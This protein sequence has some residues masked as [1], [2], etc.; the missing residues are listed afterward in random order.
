MMGQMKRHYLEQADRDAL[1]EAADKHWRENPP[2]L[3]EIF[4]DGQFRW[5]SRDVDAIQGGMRIGDYILVDDE[6]RDTFTILFKPTGE[7]GVFKKE[8]FVAHVAAFF[9]LHF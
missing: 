1:Q 8:D 5:H 2:V 4:D 6:G 7:M 3:G 9:G